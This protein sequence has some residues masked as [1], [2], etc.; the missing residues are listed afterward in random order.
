M[1]D[2][3]IQTPSKATQKA[4]KATII[5][6]EFSETFIMPLSYWTI[7]QYKAHWAASC[8]RFL[9]G[10]SPGILLVT[11]SGPPHKTHLF[12]SWLLYRVGN[13]VQIQNNITLPGVDTCKS[14]DEVVDIVPKTYRECTDDLDELTGRPVAISS[15]KVSIASILDFRESLVDEVSSP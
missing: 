10:E 5:I 9:A 15:W 4:V 14:W 13:Y 2:I 6:G 12:L 1:F 7:S 3:T 8:Q 11:L